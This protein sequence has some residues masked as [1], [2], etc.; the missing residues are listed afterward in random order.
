MHQPEKLKLHRGAGDALAAAFEMVVTPAL[1]AL[2]GW[3]IDSRLGLF[4]TFTLALAGI[5]LCYE[6][7]KLCATY[8]RNLDEEL[9]ERRKHYGQSVQ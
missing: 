9:Q 8:G 1:F 2:L 3:V 6:T 5:V 4:P 7:Y